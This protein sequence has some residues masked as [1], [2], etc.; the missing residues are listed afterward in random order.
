MDVGR[1][2]SINK[3]LRLI[4]Q[5]TG[6]FPLQ[7]RV[8]LYV[9]GQVLLIRDRAHLWGEIGVGPRLTS[10]DRRIDKRAGSIHIH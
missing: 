8:L 7:V 6:A 4:E 1:L 2:N 5:V 9:L 3:N 10:P